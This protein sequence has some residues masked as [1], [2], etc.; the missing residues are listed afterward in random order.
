MPSDT[1]NG[2]GVGSGA[3]EAI[4]GLAAR[5]AGAPLALLLVDGAWR[6]V[7]TAAGIPA[8]E[9][10]A[11]RALCERVERE[12]QGVFLSRLE[13]G[14]LKAFA[15][16]PLP[17]GGCLAV[18]DVRARTWSPGVREALAEAAALADALSR[19]DGPALAAQAGAEVVRQRDAAADRAA[20][21][22]A[23]LAEH[24]RATEALLAH[25]PGAAYRVRNDYARTAEQVSAGVRGITGWDPA[26]FAEGGRATLGGLVAPADRS[27]VWAQVQASVADRAGFDLEYRIVARSGEERWVRDCGTPVEAGGRV[28]VEGF[29][30]DVT[31]RRLADL[32]LRRSGD[33][34]RTLIEASAEVVAV[35][36]PDGSLRYVSPSVETL[37]GYSAR[38]WL[39]MDVLATVVPEDLAR[40]REVFAELVKEPGA[41]VRS[42]F[43]AHRR[44]GSVVVVDVS[45]RN[46]LNDAAVGGIV[47][48]S[49]DV[50]ARRA[51]EEALR[52]RERHFRSLLENAHEIITVL[53][54]D[55]EVR[56]V[57]PAVERILGYD[58]RAL[59][60]T[61]LFELLHPD[62]VATARRELDRA[63]AA[64]GE[65]RWLEFRVR[66]ADGTYR[67][68]ESIGTSLL[69]D[70]AVGGI[71]VNSRDAT[72]R[73]Q[74]MEALR[75]AQQQFLQSQKMEAVGRLAGGVA[76]DFNNLL[77]V[78]R[79]NAELLLL[80][81]PPDDARRAD[82][83]E[84][85]AAADRAA[86]LT[87]QLLAFSRRQVL[88]PRVLAPN[89]VVGD[90]ERIL[91]RVIG[92][93]V[94]L[95]V[96]LDPA[97]R[98]V[99][100]DPGQ[101][102]QVLLNLVVNA[103]DSM[104][105]GG[106]V[107]VET[108]N[109]VLG[110]E[111]LHTYPYVVPGE[112]VLLRV[113]D[114]GTGMA[115]ETLEHAFEPFFTTK[116]A[117]RGTGLGLS[118][119]YGI[120]KQSGGFIWIDSEPGTGTSVRVYLPPAAAEDEPEPG[121]AAAPAPAGGMETVLLAEDEEAVRRLAA[122]VLRRGGYTVLEARDGEDALRIAEAFLGRIGMVVT[123][124]VMPRMG[125]REL[126]ARLRGTRPDVPVLYVSGYAEEAVRGDGVL[127]PGTHFIGKPF[128]ADALLGAVRRVLDE[129]ATGA[130]EPAKRAARARK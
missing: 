66:H 69:N 44:D 127:D 107:T 33:Y 4:A 43:R 15:G 91:R 81:L 52:R 21:L 80:D 99:R 100:A 63:M 72:E 62:D 64:P 28:M 86:A 116:A 96:R 48:N 79:G 97:V 50:T 115:A 1:K 60:G 18:A 129:A 98:P 130:A 40:M 126:A 112:Y 16:V 82:V 22:A 35:G 49:R 11:L 12:G 120:V 30:A 3:I 45:A 110:A 113:S 102:E 20:A 108:G 128:T 2:A 78:I 25:L 74:A 34:F 87:R 95:V 90:V 83:E 109:A 58:R 6:V 14:S 104:P 118:T 26:D 70:P 125:G 56:F 55:G 37:T 23:E 92:E 5:A 114:T 57:S 24:R 65:P 67:T 36:N 7:K 53:Q 17:G 13:A 29:L 59:A 32:A 42:E 85:H 121:A 117:G 111:L 73:N 47:Y 46:L 76:H 61:R 19:G 31:E 75:L 123:D 10:D 94:E 77:T 88:Q 38:E 84:V 122:S 106:R 71:V 101:L 124:V 41:L 89:A 54:A 51:S 8:V 39:K 93:D 105:G 119:V 9:R 68:L 27:R 103:R